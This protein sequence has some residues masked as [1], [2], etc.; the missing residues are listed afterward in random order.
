MRDTSTLMVAQYFK[1]KREAVEVV[2]LSGEKVV[3]VVVVVAVDR[4]PQSYYL[5]YPR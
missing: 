5:Y 2:V 1:R 4:A 3:M